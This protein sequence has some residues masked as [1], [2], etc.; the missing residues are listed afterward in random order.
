MYT[1]RSHIICGYQTPQTETFNLPTPKLN[2][3]T[4]HQT[5]TGSDNHLLRNFP[6]TVV[7]R[8]SVCPQYLLYGCHNY[9]VYFC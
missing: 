3:R 5:K 4:K 1:P 7:G 2:P 8:S 9:R 6:G